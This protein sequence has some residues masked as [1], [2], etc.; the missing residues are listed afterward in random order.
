MDFVDMA[1]EME[2]G[3]WN[4]YTCSFHFDDQLSFS[5]HL[6]EN[7]K[8]Y[9]GKNG[10]LVNDGDLIYCQMCSGCFGNEREH[11]TRHYSTKIGVGSMI[12]CPNCYKTFKTLDEMKDHKH[13]SHEL[14]QNKPFAEQCH[15]CFRYFSNRNLRDQHIIGHLSKV[16]GHAMDKIDLLQSKMSDKADTCGMETELKFCKKM[17]ANPGLLWKRQDKSKQSGS[18]KSKTTA[19]IEIKI[20][21]ID[22]E[23]LCCVKIK[24][25]PQPSG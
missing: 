22:E 10:E 8:E 23:I 16:V 13:N 3:K 25:E 12:E 5:L 21:P 2:Q 7:H 15:I 14:Q 18:K 4:C 6:H 1:G 17:I 19:K 20:E 11:E 9:R 24:K